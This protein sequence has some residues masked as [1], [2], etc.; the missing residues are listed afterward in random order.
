[1][2]LIPIAVISSLIVGSL[3]LFAGADPP[4][5]GCSNKPKIVNY[6]PNSRYAD[7]LRHS[8]RA[9]AH[10]YEEILH[11]DRAGAETNRDMALAEVPLWS[12]LLRREREAILERQGDDPTE[13]K[14]PHDRDEYPPALS[15]EGGGSSSVWY[16]DS[17]EN[18]SAGSVMRVQL[19]GLKDGQCF[20]Y[21]R[22]PG[23]KA[24]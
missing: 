4:P 22:K 20:R 18:R 5:Q 23:P 15:Q 1:M 3:A 14:A 16:V 13:W 24:L 17:S 2:R 6:S 11:L 7:I 12:K 10:G 19:S 21:E 8:F 9:R